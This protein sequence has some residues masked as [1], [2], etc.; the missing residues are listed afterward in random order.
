MQYVI[1]ATENSLAKLSASVSWMMNNEDALIRQCGKPWDE[2]AQNIGQAVLRDKII[3]S[4]IKATLEASAML[5]L[6]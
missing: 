4:N 1:N 6:C 2:I 5:H 3:A